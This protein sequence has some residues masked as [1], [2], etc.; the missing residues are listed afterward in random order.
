MFLLVIAIS[1]AILLNRD[2]IAG[3]GAYGYPGLF[4]VNLLASATLILPVPGLAL[5]FAVGSSLNPLLV[6]LATGAGSAL[7]ELTGYMAGYSGRGVIENQERYAQ[8]QRWMARFGL[9]IIFVLSI[10]P[11]P[12]F[13]IAGIAA[14]AM[15]M[16]VWKFLLASL[17]GKTIKAALIA[18][19]GAGTMRLLVQAASGV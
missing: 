10:I 14:G 2:R 16:P 7:G 11:N 15:R 8:V 3:L 13:D 18:Y 19:L 4:L 9:W 12:A 1:A 5:A 6:G 17:A